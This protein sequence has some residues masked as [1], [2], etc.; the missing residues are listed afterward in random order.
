MV[1][2]GQLS[3]KGHVVEQHRPRCSGFGF[4]GN[5]YG[6]GYR[7][8]WMEKDDCRGFR[9]SSPVLPLS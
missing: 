9:L 1:F 7:L 4:P 8:H 6:T 5:I 2:I 3:G